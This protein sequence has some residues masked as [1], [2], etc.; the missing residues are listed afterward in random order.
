MTKD[1]LNSSTG[2]GMT[3]EF[4]SNYSKENSETDEKK[5]LRIIPSTFYLKL[6][7]KVGFK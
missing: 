6:H 2:N 7:L 3:I 5:K 1:A 4:S